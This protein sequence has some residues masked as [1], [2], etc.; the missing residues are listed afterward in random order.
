[1]DPISKFIMENIIETTQHLMMPLM[2]FVFFAAVVM[3]VLVY[4]TAR[5]QFKFAKEF[6]KRVRRTF[7]DPQAERITSFYKLT[8]K[9][10]QTTFYENYELRR[11]YKHRNLDSVATVAD[12]LFLIEDGIARLVNDTLRQ[13]RYLKREGFPPR[14]VEITKGVFDANPVFTRLLGIFPI[15][16]VNEL[17]NILPGLLIIGGIFGTFLGVARGLPN[18]GGMDLGNIE[19]TKKIMD[20]FLVTISQAMVKSIVGIALSVLM[21]LVNTV[22]SP[23]GMYYSL[24]NR[25]SDSL[26]HLWNETTTNEMD[27]DEAVTSRHQEKKVA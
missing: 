24:I 12:R 13:V 20:L 8:K 16:T 10:F 26:E 9:L 21:T 18:L 1:M 22:L 17:L 25:Y 7:A 27:T 5:S 11:K 15:G 6:E 23:E 2:I 4:Y 14:M 3:R 19:E